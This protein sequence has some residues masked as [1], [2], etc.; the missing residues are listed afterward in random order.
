M[1]AA[2]EV[3]D[4][5]A[6]C[7]MW[8]AGKQFAFTVFDDTDFATRE[9][10]QDVY[11]F[12]ADCGFR[13]TKSVWV[14][15]GD[16]HRGECRGQTCDDAE[17]LQWVRELQAR[18]FEIGFHN[19]TWHGLPRRELQAALEKFVALFGHDPMTAAN[20][21]GVEES[22]Y[23][24]EARLT[25]WRVPLYGLLTRF[26]NRG[27]FRGHVEGDEYFWGDLCQQ[28]VKYFRNFVYRDINT[29]KICP[30]MPYYDPLKP[31]VRGW[32][33]SAD[34]H[35]VGAFNQCLHEAHQDR[36]EQEGGACIMYT[37]FA[38]GF[39]RDGKLDPRF[40]EL[41][42]RL[43]KKNGWF[44]PAAT[45]LDHL[46]AGHG[47]RQ[48]T[49]AQRRRLECRWLRETFPRHQLSGVFRLIPADDLS[50]EVCACR[51]D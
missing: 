45:L 50:S 32:F 13:T 12:L 5:M 8:P 22:I 6:Q 7:K 20:H 17:Y 38:K 41:M 26:H 35:D 30:Y 43:A 1:P 23:W 42:T 4:K 46:A 31:Y 29:L 40:R 27:Q 39:Y 44:V 21:T 24:G 36:L 3:N 33:A 15:A 47:P 10:V 18:Q 34:G 19:G 2:R 11:A 37:H 25:G 9:N 14:V 49:N 16:P 28:H 48:I 51:G